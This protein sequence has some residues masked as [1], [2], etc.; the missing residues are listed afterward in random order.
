[1]KSPTVEQYQ[2]AERDAYAKLINKK[3]R[4]RRMRRSDVKA[5]NLQR[6]TFCSWR[7]NCNLRNVWHSANEKNK[8]NGHPQ[9]TYSKFKEE[10]EL[11]KNDRKKLSKLNAA[12]YERINLMNTEEFKLYLDN[13]IKS[14]EFKN[15]PPWDYSQQSFPSMEGHAGDDAKKIGIFS[16]FDLIQGNVRVAFCHIIFLN[17]V[18]DDIIKR[19]GD[20]NGF[21]ALMK[22]RVGIINEMSEMRNVRLMKIHNK[23]FK[24]TDA[25]NHL[26]PF[27][28]ADTF[29][30]VSQDLVARAILHG[31]NVVPYPQDL[32]A[33]AR[34]HGINVVP[35]FDE[36][37]DPAE[38]AGTSNVFCYNQERTKQQG[39]MVVASDKVSVFVD[40]IGHIFIVGIDRA[41]APG[42]NSFAHAGGFNDIK[43]DGT[44]ET[45]LEAAT[46][47]GIEEAKHNITEL[48]YTTTTIVDTKHYIFWD[49]RAFGCCG[50]MI[51]A[52]VC[53]TY[54]I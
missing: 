5:L 44:R 52:V 38:I 14:N 50:A 33:R 17:T 35:Y 41:N 49:F 11:I 10:Y 20:A 43:K 7:K 24:E 27:K 53:V 54:Y 1:M 26:K 15:G 6:R 45:V 25:L 3:R 51:G 29:K 19:H 30:C 9:M 8:K 2:S 22:E 46:R 18:I 48:G 21:F 16:I 37:D 12:E 23:I 36:T 32:V 39:Y 4:A 31:I 47:E 28:H 42:I 13:M 34:L 40:S